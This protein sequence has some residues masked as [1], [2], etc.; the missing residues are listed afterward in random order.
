M[1]DELDQVTLARAR[2]G[3]PSAFAALVAL[4]QRRVFALCGRMLTGRPPAAVEDV[5]QEVFLRV[6]RGLRDFDPAG[7][8]RLSTWILTVATRACLNVL[9][10]ATREAPLVDGPTEEAEEDPEL[11]ALHRERRR[12]VEAALG[13][14]AEEMRAVIVL[15]AY[16]DFDYD[17]IAAALS[18]EVGTV[19]SRLCRA[20]AALRAALGELGAD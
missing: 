1:A 2:R 7:P 14:L 15:R 18:L 16:H 3:D 20:R 12:R 17:E 4:Y 8:A 9:R 5:A 10:R 13:A 19:K 6:F 11:T